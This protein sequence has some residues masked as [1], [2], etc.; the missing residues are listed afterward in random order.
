MCLAGT[1]LKHPAA[2]TLLEYATKGYPSKT[3]PNWT[4]E[5]LEAAVA[6]GPH[7]SALVPDARYQHLKEVEEKVAKGQAKIVSWEHLKEHLPP[8]LKISNSNDTTQ[9]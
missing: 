5:Q 4:M 7:E 3:G 1:G 2:K 9:V 8:N 6:R